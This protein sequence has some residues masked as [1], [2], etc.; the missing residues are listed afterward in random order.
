MTGNALA[1]MMRSS[2]ATAVDTADQYHGITLDYSEASIYSVES[3]LAATYHEMHSG[4]MAR[5]LRR[6]PSAAQLRLLSMVWG[7]YVGEVMRSH[8]GGEWQEPPAG[9]LQGQ[10]V[11]SINGSQ[12]S[13][14]DKVRR[15]LVNGDED[16][17]WAYY[18]AVKKQVLEP[19]LSDNTSDNTTDG[20]QG[21]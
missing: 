16:N 19:G 13:P 9:T 11:L 2:A 20:G 12:Q 18:Q 1:S 17:V 8:F 6:R 10:P 7:A 3:I 14:P 5:L 15:R 21:Q 4:R